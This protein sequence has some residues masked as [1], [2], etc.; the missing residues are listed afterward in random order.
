VSDI[1]T[2]L[3]SEEQI[4]RRVLALGDDITHDY[5]GL[6]PVLISVLKGGVVFM[7]DLMRAVDLPLRLD[8]M[9]ISSYGSGAEHAGVVRIMKDLDHD[10][11]GEHVVIVEDI[12]DTGLTLSYLLSALWAREPAS[13]SVCTLLDKSIRRIPTLEIRYVGF[14]CPDRF[15]VGYGLDYQQRY[16]NLP[17][18]LAVN[19]QA[20]LAANPTALDWFLTA[21][22]R[23]FGTTSGQDVVGRDAGPG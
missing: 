13:I 14:D 2:V 21:E 5:R 20:G 9:S 11:G 18:V 7:A 19:D 6:A 15:V 17:F 3:F 22:G 1:A 16:R 10:I 8:F 23:A 4:R 12:I